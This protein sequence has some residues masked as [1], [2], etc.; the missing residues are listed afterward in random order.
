VEERVA[1]DL[2]AAELEGA[3]GVPVQVIGVAD[4]PAVDV[5]GR[6]QAVTPEDPMAWN[7]SA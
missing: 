6:V 7:W 4:E 5:E 3:D 1:G 2:V